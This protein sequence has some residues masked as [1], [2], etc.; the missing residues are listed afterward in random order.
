[1]ANTVLVAIISG[2]LTLAG[3]ALT[4]WQTSKKTNENFLVAQA[5]MNKQIEHLTEEVKKH[6]GFAEKIP[7]LT[8]KITVANHRID[9]L[10]RKMERI[11]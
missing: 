6:N 9:D 8:E 3:T 1:M 10:E 11:D 4:V 7:V 2:L 5:V